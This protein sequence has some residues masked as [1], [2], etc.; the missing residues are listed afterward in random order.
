MRAR[1]GWIA[2][3]ALL[4]APFAAAKDSPPLACAGSFVQG[5][6]VLCRTAPGAAVIVDGVER[7][8]ADAEGWFVAGFDRDSAGQAKIAVR[9]PEGEAERSYLITTRQFS[10]Q[11]VDGLPP[12]TV[13]PDDP[14][15]LKKIKRDQAWK[16]TA[17]ASRA[18]LAGWREGFRFPIAQPHRISG[19]W[20]NQRVLN[21]VPRTPHYGLDIAVPTGTAI[22]APAAGKVVLAQPDM[23]FE[24]GL[25][26][27][28]HGQGLFTMY[29]HMSRIDVKEGDVVAQGQMLGA[30]GRTG[31]ATGPHLCWRMR[32]RDRNL[33]PSDAVNALAKA[34]AE[35]GA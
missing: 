7:G 17:S 29:L 5:G 2:A 23:H 16:K 27:L 21:G 3:A 13:T 33:D 24:G 14:E 15:V 4:W 32:W 19:P 28:D 8:A 35:L 18:A 12:Q 31:R 30:V 34:K 22:I 11:R 26:Y 6:V 1:G 10:I 20:G 9:T 25:I